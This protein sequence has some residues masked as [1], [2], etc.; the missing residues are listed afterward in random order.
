MR[1]CIV[2][3]LFL[4]GILMSISL[5]PADVPHLINYQG[6]LTDDNEVWLEGKHNLTFSIYEDSLLGLPLWTEGH[7]SLEVVGGVFSVILGSITAIPGS[8]FEGVD[9][10]MGITV[11]ADPEMSPRMRMT[12][13]PWAMRSGLADT[14]QT[15]VEVPTHGHHGLDAADGDPTNAVY[16]DDAGN[17]G[18][19]TTSPASELEVV[20]NVEADGY[21]INGVP[22]GTSTDSYW[23]EID[24]NI[25]YDTGNVGIGTTNPQ[26]LLQIGEETFYFY[27]DPNRFGIDD[28]DPDA[29]L[30][31]ATPPEGTLDLLMLSSSPDADG[32]L[33]IVKNSGKVGIGTSNPTNHELVV[34]DNDVVTNSGGFGLQYAGGIG[35]MF[36]LANGGPHLMSGAGKKL[37]LEALDGGDQ[38][39]IT[40][41]DNNVGIGT[42][43]P[44]EELDVDGTVR[45]TGFDMPTGAD[46]GYVLTS[47]GA[48]VGTWQEASG[49]VGGVGTPNFIPKWADGTT[50]DD[51]VIRQID[52]MVAIGP[53]LPEHLLD[54]DGD[55]SLD[56]YLYHNGSDELT[57]IE[58]NDYQID[59]AAGRQGSSHKLISMSGGPAVP[60]Y[61]VINEEGWDTDFRVEAGA[62]P[63]DEYALFVHGANGRVGIGTN[64]PD[65]KLHVDGNIVFGEYLYHDGDADTHIKCTTNQI[66]VYAG[67]TWL[68]SADANGAGGG[69]E[70][71]INRSSADVD[72]RV[73]ASGEDNA[74]VVDGNTGYVGIGATD[75]YRPLQ[76]L[77]DR[78]VGA[79]EQMLASLATDAGDGAGLMLGY[80]ANGANTTGAILRSSHALPLFLGTSANNRAITI[81]N[82]GDVGIGTTTPNYTLDVDGDINVSGGYNIKKGGTNYNHPDY[83]FEPDYELMSLDELRDH[84][85]REKSLPNVISAD[86]VK[87]ND[88]FKMDELLIQM[89]EKIEEQ[90]LYIFQLE[91]RITQLEENR[92]D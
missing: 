33:F 81:E 31:V 70:V 78:G 34:W 32:D 13:V 59:M 79:G 2:C 43:S 74:L 45:M 27:E 36:T 37:R 67:N 72:F 55:I 75:F 87:Q 7:D 89:L 12:S 51:S 71:V 25:Y 82:D 86:E 19:G 56:Q 28:I 3:S 90:T 63:V 50:L 52:G 49:T 4:I 18:I 16:V 41:D 80:Y 44:T 64:D 22:V 39:G 85:R 48:G 21:T 58:F 73:E 68:I 26:A 23:A 91:E 47:N 46:D 62:F 5:S 30:E 6:T 35:G 10:W 24:S 57:Y 69:P 40:I 92:R 77:E 17:A 65:T 53:T 11:D 54:V 15:V 88:G 14:A 60:D 9:R 38:S 61:V 84:V 1:R 76:V 66:D 8:T 83:V 42:T 20:G 29:Q